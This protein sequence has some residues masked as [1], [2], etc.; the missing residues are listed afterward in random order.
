MKTEREKQ[1]KCCHVRYEQKR[2]EPVRWLK[3]DLA[4]SDTLGKEGLNGFKHCTETF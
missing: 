1:Q 3:C 2:P 4:S